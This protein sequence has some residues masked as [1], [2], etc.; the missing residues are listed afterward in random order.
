VASFW[1]ILLV[2]VYYIIGIS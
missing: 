2:L 1:Y